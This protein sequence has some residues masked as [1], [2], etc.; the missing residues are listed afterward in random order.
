MRQNLIFLLGLILVV[1]SCDP[2]IPTD[3][4]EEYSRLPESLDFNIHV[5]PILSDKCFLCHGPDKG[6]RK[7]GLHLDEEKAA[8]AKLTNSPGKRAVTPGKLQKSEVF[9]ESFPRIQ[10]IKCRSQNLI[11]SC[12]HMKRR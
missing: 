6:S 3:V 4:A 7:A 11:W 5:K 9:I 2:E 1:A 10:T 8:Y 12:Q